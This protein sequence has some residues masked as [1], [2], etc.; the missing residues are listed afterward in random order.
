[1]TKCTKRPKPHLNALVMNDLDVKLTEEVL[2]QLDMEDTLDNEFC[3]L[4]LNA[5]AGTDKGEAIKLRAM[6]RTK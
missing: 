1:M 6:V 4:S 3:K 2:H 5:I